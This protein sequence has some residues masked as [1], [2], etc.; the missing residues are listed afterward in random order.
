MIGP[1]HHSEN[2]VPPPGGWCGKVVTPDEVALRCAVWKPQDRTEKGTVVVLNGRIE[3]IE[4]YYEVIGELLTR[5]FTVAS[6]DWRGQGGSQRL[7]RDPSRGHVRRFEDYVIDLT[8]FVAQV[9]RKRCPPPY[10][11][12][13]HSMGA[14]TALLAASVEKVPFERMVLVA[15]MVKLFRSDARQNLLAAI[16]RTAVYA[17]FSS[18]YVPPIGGST[19]HESAFEGNRFT[20]DPR[21][22]ERT[23]TILEQAPHLRV[24]RPTFG[25]V[26]AAF[27]AMSRLARHDFPACVKIPSLMLVCAQDRIVYNPA[28]EELAMAM[29]A[30]SHVFV[31]GARHELLMERDVFRTQF[32]GAFDAFV[33]GAA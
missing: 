31:A 19:G 29:G 28:I 24:G 8:S 15:P 10:F 12:L 11:A 33:P 1:L 32:W 14:T 16:A 13:A 17:G 20:A 27:G 5:G 2:V 25:W 23:R 21:R 22:F 30:A 6:M 7:L 26:H 9:V 4:K 18:R 3:F